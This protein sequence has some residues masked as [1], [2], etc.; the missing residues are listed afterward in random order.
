MKTMIK[1]LSVLTLSV[2]SCSVMAAD[3]AV[4]IT[5]FA[6]APPSVE[7]PVGTKVIWT[8]QDKATHSVISDS[9]V[10]SS[11]PLKQG[12]NFSYTFTGAGT[13]AY[14]CGYHTYMTGVIIVK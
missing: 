6:F 4:N 9:G 12:D 7:V 14:H 1:F 13:Y 2:F 8:N 10:F 3:T 5:Q 11:P